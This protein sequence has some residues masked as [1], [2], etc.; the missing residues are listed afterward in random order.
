M[1]VKRIRVKIANGGGAKLEEAKRLYSLLKRNEFSA[2]FELL[3]QLLQQSEGRNDLL[4][5]LQ[6]VWREYYVMRSISRAYSKIQL[7]QF[8]KLLGV[9][10]QEDAKVLS[11]FN[12]EIQG[13]YITPR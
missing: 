11:D 7:S 8:K 2:A 5:I 12:V 10:A 9:Q 6:K 1:L 4:L 3:D 13:G